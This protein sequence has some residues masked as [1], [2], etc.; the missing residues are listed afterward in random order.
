MAVQDFGSLSPYRGV[1]LF[2]QLSALSP[3]RVCNVGVEKAS[4]EQSSFSGTPLSISFGLEMS[5]P[6]L[7][8]QIFSNPSS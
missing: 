4:N 1:T 6:L 8:D 2:L 5:F 3:T 7:P